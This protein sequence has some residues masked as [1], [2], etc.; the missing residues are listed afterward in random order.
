[1]RPGDARPHWNKA[2]A[3]LLAGDYA[4]GWALYEYRWKNDETKHHR[5]D[6]AHPLW[7][8]DTPL[9][10]KTILLHAEQ[11]LGDTIQFCR[12]AKHVAELGARVI[13]QVQPSLLP[14]LGSVEGVAQLVGEGKALPE[15]DLHCPLL[16]LPHALRA[17]VDCIPSHVSYLTAD[18]VRVGQWQ[19]RLGPRQR[20]RV[21]L[22]WS[23]AAGHDNDRNRSIALAELLRHLPAGVDYIS[24]QKDLRPADAAVIAGSALRHFGDDLRDFADTAALCELMD[25]VISVDTS[26]AH[27]A[28]AL[29]R[30]TWVLLP[31]APDWRWLLGTDRSPWYPTARLYRQGADGAWAGVL[32]RLAVDVAALVAR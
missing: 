17:S 21:G 18:A 31:H 1:M 27:L 15:F 12:Y 19:Q 8:G 32:D 29:G 10:G 4:P 28:G 5:R 2:L 7:L 23:G 16:S 9:A 30:P 14:L 24:L 3:L 6:F 11:G 26:V 25:V 20:P 13:L 22:A